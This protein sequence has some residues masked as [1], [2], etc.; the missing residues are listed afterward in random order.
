MRTNLGILFLVLIIVA[1]GFSQDQQISA[2]LSSLVEAERP[3]A[4]ACL[5]KGIRAS[6]TE[7]FADDGIA[8]QP[9]PV[10]YKETVREQPASLQPDAVTIAWEPIFSDISA[11]FNVG[12][13]LVMQANRSYIRCA[14]I[15]YGMANVQTFRQKLP[16][17]LVRA[18]QDSYTLNK[19]ID[20]FVKTALARARSGIYQLSRRPARVRYFGRQ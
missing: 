3:F 12:L 9:Q 10:K 17:L 14:V 6:F 7:F 4:A 13:P 2:V 11:N 8:F 1:F 16:L 15:Y 20:E 19:A 5:E 18:G